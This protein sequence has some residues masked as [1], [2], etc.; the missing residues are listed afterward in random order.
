ML[1]KAKH[2]MILGREKGSRFRNGQER[3]QRE[4][5]TGRRGERQTGG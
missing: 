3:R 5:E 1:T 4:K 2:S